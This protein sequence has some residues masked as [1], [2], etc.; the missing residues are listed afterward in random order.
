MTSVAKDMEIVFG[1]QLREMP[2]IAINIIRAHPACDAT[3][4]HFRY[5]TVYVTIAQRLRANTY[6]NI[7]NIKCKVTKVNK[8][9][10]MYIRTLIQYLLQNKVEI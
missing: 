9:I 7:L 2:P 1:L 6:E 3:N 10:Y 8:I 4:T 5:E